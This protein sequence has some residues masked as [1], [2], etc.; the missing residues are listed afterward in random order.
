MAIDPARREGLCLLLS[1]L[2]L[3][4]GGR[5]PFSGWQARE[6]PHDGPRCPSDP[7]SSFSLPA[8]ARWAGVRLPCLCRRKQMLQSELQLD[9]QPRS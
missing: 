7:P 4:Q 9:C 5:K 1:E 8:V 6:N 3:Y 2:P